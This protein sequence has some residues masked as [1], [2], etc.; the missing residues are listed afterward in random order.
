MYGDFIRATRRRG[1]LTQTELA[2]IT[3]IPQSNISAYERDHRVPS[4]DT[5]NR[6]VVG[7]G[8]LLAAVAG[9]D[10]V[11]CALP[12]AGWFADEDL[13]ARDPSDPAESGAPLASD[14]PI[15]ERLERIHRVLELADQQRALR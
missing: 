5:L 3:G 13:P 15:E 6:I 1:G 4:A 10:E 9:E 12:R 14:A 2:E 7:C 8:Y 11:V